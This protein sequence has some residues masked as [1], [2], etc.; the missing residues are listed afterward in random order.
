MQSAGKGVH[1]VLYW[2]ARIR[3]L[4]HNSAVCAD[5][6]ALCW[7]YKRLLAGLEQLAMQ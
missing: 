3:T 2:Q 7:T 5:V 6:C 4:A 1:A